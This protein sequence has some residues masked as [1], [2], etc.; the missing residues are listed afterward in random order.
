MCQHCEVDSYSKLKEL[1]P[2]FT[3]P[4]QLDSLYKGLGEKWKESDPIPKPWKDHIEWAKSA[5]IIFLHVLY[6]YC[7]LLVLFP[8]NTRY[9]SN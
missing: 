4:A 8:W 1:Y 2:D 3:K 6:I 9:G 5:V 7:Y